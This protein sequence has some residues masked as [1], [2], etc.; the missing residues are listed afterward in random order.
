M[1]VL[2]MYK[3]ISVFM[4]SFAVMVTNVQATIF[5]VTVRVQS[6]N[7]V[8]SDAYNASVAVAMLNKYG[9]EHAQ[10]V[11][12]TIKVQVFYPRPVFRPPPREDLQRSH[13]D[14]IKTS[15]N[16]L[17][18]G[19]A[20]VQLNKL[21]SVLNLLEDFESSQNFGDFVTIFV[22]SVGQVLGSLTAMTCS[23]LSNTDAGA[24]NCVEI[25]EVMVDQDLNGDGHTGKPPANGDGSGGGGGNDSGGGSSGGGSGGSSTYTWW[26]CSTTAGSGGSTTTCVKHSVTIIH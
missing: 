2:K 1:K 20:I 23:A 11:G 26:E 14:S 7:D 25:A 8:G 18:K 15:I 9:E 12:D 21:Y 6:L 13:D 22:H 24:T 19:N 17:R 10:S 4:L 3:W 16:E 5:D